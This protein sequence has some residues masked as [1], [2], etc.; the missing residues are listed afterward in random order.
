MSIR[1]ARKSIRYNGLESRFT[2]YEGDLRDASILANEAPFDLVTGS[3]PYW[4]AGDR[5][6]R[7]PIRKQY[8]R[9]S[10]SAA[11]SLDYAAAAA[12]ILAPGGFFVFVFPT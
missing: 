2:V 6:R 4:P 8:P 11:P 9:E 3:P 10:R 1:L 12:H 7:P 5:G